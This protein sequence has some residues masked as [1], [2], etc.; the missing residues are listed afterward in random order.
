MW[1]IA[2]SL[3]EATKGPPPFVTEGGQPIIPLKLNLTPQEKKDLVLY[4]KALNG[5]QAE[6]VIT[7]IKVN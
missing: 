6:P 4:L 5:V 3:G 2:T 7:G 1:L